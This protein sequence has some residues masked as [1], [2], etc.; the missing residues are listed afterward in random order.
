MIYN[1][2]S[3]SG[4]HALAF[5]GATN[6]LA[7]GPNSGTA[8]KIPCRRIHADG[9]VVITGITGTNVT[10]PDYGAGY[11]WDIQAKAIVSGSGVVIW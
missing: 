4:R 11:V 6:L 8:S 9:E 1:P 2:N 5:S 3:D 10:L 7:V